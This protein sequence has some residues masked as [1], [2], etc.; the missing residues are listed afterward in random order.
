MN[1][2]SY[3]R[4]LGI[5]IIVTAVLM[6]IENGGQS[7]TADLK[8]EGTSVVLAD[9]KE[10]SESATA[11]SSSIKKQ[12]EIEERGYSS[13][14]S[15]SMKKDEVAETSKTDAA[16]QKDEK[17][18]TDESAKKDEKVKADESAKKDE[19][20][21]TDESINSDEKADSEKLNLPS[22]GALSD[23]GQAP[24][25]DDAKKQ[26]DK[27]QS[28]EKD[29]DVAKKDVI[30]PGTIVDVTIKPG[31]SSEAIAKECERLG[32]VE[33]GPAFD[34]YLSTYGYDRKLTTGT[35]HIKIGM[36]EA[37]IAQILTSKAD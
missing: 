5:G 9:M 17:A 35:H 32:L 28:Q 19:K 33:L 7:S 10:L 22:A 25:G 16:S 2:K 24:K 31:Q 6:G 11:S 34:K 37:E 21:E 27:Q 14:S 3:L 23:D 4:G 30:A 12:K 29:A 8:E 18:K 20:A 26:N 15:S 36:T 13:S 1:L